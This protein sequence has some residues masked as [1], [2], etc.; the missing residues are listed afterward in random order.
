VALDELFDARPHGF[1]RRS[2]EVE[3]IAD[4]VGVDPDD[5]ATDV[6]HRTAR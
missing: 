1:V 2:R 4:T 6:E 5:F 3:A